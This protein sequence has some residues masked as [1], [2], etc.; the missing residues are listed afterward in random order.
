LHPKIPLHSLTNLGMPGVHIVI[1]SHPS[2]TWGGG[3]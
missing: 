1:F 3:G 2:G